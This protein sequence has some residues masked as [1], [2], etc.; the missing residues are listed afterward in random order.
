MVRS[1]VVGAG[2]FSQVL[3]D[4]ES[5][6]RGEA[7]FE[8]L[9]SV[10]DAV[11]D[12]ARAMRAAGIE[13][14]EPLQDPTRDVLIDTWNAALEQSAHQ[15]LVVH[16]SGHGEYDNGSLYLAV[17]GSER[18][19]RLR[20]TSVEADALLKDALSGKSPVL[21]LLDVCQAGYA[22]TS[23]ALNDLVRA[24]AAR[25]PSTR[26][27]WVIGACAA[28]ETTQQA[29]FS[30]ATATVLHRLAEGLIDVSPALE[31]VP[32]ETFAADVARELARAGG[33]GQSVVRTPT[34]LALEEVPGFFPNRSYAEDAPGRF[35]AGVDAALRQLALDTDPS[36]DLLHFAT[37]AAGNRRA[38]VCQF[39]GRTSQLEQI[40][41]WLDDP[42]GGQARLLVVTGGPGSGKSALLGVTAC[43]LHPE[44]QP[45]RRRVR[46]RIAGFDPRPR[47][48]ILAVHARQLTSHQI[49]DSLLRQLSALTG[50]PTP[51]SSDGGEE[52]QASEQGDG[53]GFDKL[54]A[55][56]R[57]TGPV[58]IVLDALDEATDP[59]AVVRELVLPLAGAASD[60]GDPTPHCRVMVGTRPWWDALHELHEHAVTRPE[61]LLTLDPATDDDRQ[62]LASDLAEYLGQL[63]EDHYSPSVSGTIAH[64]LAH[65]A[66]TGAFLIAALYADHLVQQ[67]EAGRPPAADDIADNLPCTITDVFDLHIQSLVTADPWVLPVLQVLGQARGQGMPLDLLHEAALAHTHRDTEVDR[68]PTLEDTRRALLKAAFYL[69]T[70]PDSDH[71][72]LYRYFHQALVDHTA[73]TTDPV[74]VHD[75]LVRT[76]PAPDGTP[77]WELAHPYLK[78]HA[79]A[80]ALAAGRA[81]VDDLLE[82]PL[83]LL[84]ADP[85]GLAPYLH[86]ATTETA[87][88]HAH[89]YRTTAT[90]HPERH[91]TATRRDLLAVDAAAWKAPALARA[92]S[93]AP[94]DHQASP[95]VPVWAT[96][97]TAHPALLHTLMK[98]TAAVAAVATA[99]TA[100]GQAL[101]VSAGGG[102]T[103]VWDLDTGEH[104]ARFRG[105]SEGPVATA[106]LPDGRV[107]AVTIEKG[108]ARVWDMLSGRHLHH[109]ASRSRQLS[110]VATAVLPDGRAL[111]I[112]TDGGA[113]RVWDLLSGRHL[114]GLPGHAGAVRSVA[115]AVL[116]DGRALA[117]TIDRTKTAQ[118]WDLVA[119]KRLRGLPGH[120]GAV[121]S[122]ATAVLPDGR[123]LA[124][125]TGIGGQI[126]VWN[127]E[128]GDRVHSLTGPA[129]VVLAVATLVLPNGQALA[130]TT[131]RTRTAQVWDLVTGKRLYTLTGHTHAVLAVATLV[132]PDGRA[133]AVTT[134]RV[135]KGLVWDLAAAK[136]P[137]HPRRGHL[138]AVGAVATATRSGGRTLALSADNLVV[139]VRDLVSGEQ[140]YSLTGHTGSLLELATATSSSGRVLAVTAGFFDT[141][142]VWDLESSQPEPLSNLAD[143]IRAGRRAVLPG[144]EVLTV[145]TG[146]QWPGELATG[147][148]AD[149]LDQI[150]D[151]PLPQ[152]SLAAVLDNGMVVVTE[153]GRRGRISTD[154]TL[155]SF[156]RPGWHTR[157]S[158]EIA[159]MIMADGRKI[160]V[161]PGT[162]W[163]KELHTGKH[164][165]PLTRLAT[166]FDPASSIA[167]TTLAD[168]TVLAVTVGIGGGA[169]V[170]DMN[171][172]KQ[173]HNLGNHPGQVLAVATAVLPDG[174]ALAITTHSTGNVRVWNL[175]EGRQIG[176]EISLP[177]RNVQAVTATGNGIV[178][179]YGPDVAHFVWNTPDSTSGCNTGLAGSIVG[180]R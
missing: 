15:P 155:P 117:I 110:S 78:R 31:H 34:D 118:V 52:K 122:V 144:G 82:D 65:H 104:V 135:G 42:T 147:S 129:G 46:A 116:P 37:R 174:R 102:E 153:E 13:V 94:V 115:T 172:Q 71:H 87:V 120:A 126:R 23:Q 173:L 158:P 19:Q 76:V 29:M 159:A 162:R 79:A 58:V 96:S 16:F 11:H 138:R 169:H 85:D 148:E 26:N 168:G 72:L 176:R 86:H 111:A 35:L 93:T 40:Q 32:V 7:P 150:T 141:V 179:G 151:G 36:L 98:H 109:L 81:H 60:D 99:A 70:A 92:L 22:V 18:G 166:R 47:A 156:R 142:Q 100:E 75:A 146:E 136:H 152:G 59:A 134:D 50:G 39:S 123:A 140:L 43:L 132:L 74:V 6:A 17:R 97:S 69:R 33:L 101:A 175:A 128:T 163:V 57:A 160:L 2:G 139:Q 62:V 167:V 84:H 127:L 48:R 63:L 64:R 3:V 1:L 161:H 90:H 21:F 49:I 137:M 83:F 133:L 124:I 180:D 55:R 121:R 154:W 113:A 14:G 91:L 66:E 25:K 170:W 89:I 20:P 4:E 149:L 164:L 125:T 53:A 143:T 67:A 114:R 30:R 61:T 45:L 8:H 145:D 28:G 77:D 56:I 41:A 44:L 88:H 12:V 108:R 112:T 177:F 105:S 178:L 95:L 9:P 27:V 157:S 51:A 5:A 54:A 73:P 10:A 24:A 107:L 106:A 131:D 171:S 38:D 103:R 80:H 68:K 130:I 119:G 165:A